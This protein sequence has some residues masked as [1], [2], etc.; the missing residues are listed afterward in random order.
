MPPEWTTV[1]FEGRQLRLSESEK[2]VAQPLH[3]DKLIQ[4]GEVPTISK[5]IEAKCRV[6]STRWNRRKVMGKDSEMKMSNVRSAGAGSQSA[7]VSV[8]EARIR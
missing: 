6:N 8:W 1:V 2:G 4:S 7:L 5:F 3:F